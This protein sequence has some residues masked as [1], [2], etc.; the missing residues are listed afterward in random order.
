MGSFEFD[1]MTNPG[2]ESREEEEVEA[3]QRAF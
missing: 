3:S 2:F 1:E